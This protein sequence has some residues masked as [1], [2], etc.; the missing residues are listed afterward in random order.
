MT[1]PARNLLCAVGLAA[2]LVGCTKKPTEEACDEAIANIRKLTGHSNTEDG[3]DRRAA[4]RSCRAQSNAD[5][6]E[7]Y[8]EAQTVQELYGCGGDMAAAVQEME[9]KAGAG[10]GAAGSA[11]ASGSGAAGAAPAQGSG[12]SGEGSGSGR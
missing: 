11:P 10:S 2:A 4:V 6:V 3:P 5:T 12:A 7:C 1:R 9:K 8:A